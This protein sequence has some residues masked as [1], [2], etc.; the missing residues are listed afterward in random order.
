[1]DWI[2]DQL[3]KE[4]WSPYAAGVFL[5]LINVL[6]L[7]LISKPLGASTAFAKL[8]SYVVKFVHPSEMNTTYFKFILPPGINFTVVVVIGLLIGG[9]ISAKMSGDFRWRSITDEQWITFFG[10]SV[11]KRWVIGFFGAF[12]IEYGAQLAGGCTSGLAISGTMQLAPSGLIFIGAMF[13]SG[14]L[15]AFLI[16]GKKY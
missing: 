3:K 13:A 4:K 12:I 8:T 15:T 11:W 1:M 14:I 5:G 2:I 7:L 10:P 9:F 6:A 16:Y